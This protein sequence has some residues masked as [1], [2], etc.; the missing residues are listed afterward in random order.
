[1]ISNG[2]SFEVRPDFGCKIFRAAT[3]VAGHQNECALWGL[4][5]P[6]R[7]E[8]AGRA[9]GAM[10]HHRARQRLFSLA[11]G[12]QDEATGLDARR[13]VKLTNAM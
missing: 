7:K 8:N 9:G 11:H 13:H 3:A 5:A 12:G 1:M 4:C 2:S 10:I 6:V